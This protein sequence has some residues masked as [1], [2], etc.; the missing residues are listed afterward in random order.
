MKSKIFLP[1]GLAT[2]AACALPACDDYLEV[3]SPSSFSD[4]YVFGTVDEINKNL[5]AVYA[6]MLSSNTYGGAYINTYCLNSDVEMTTNGSE[7]Q[8]S[9]GNSYRFFDATADGSN[10]NNTWRDA[11][12]NIEYANN[13][14]CGVENTEFY[15]DPKN[16]DHAEV[17][18]MIGEAKC[19]R[20][21]NYL[22]LVVLCGDVPF[23]FSRT[24]DNYDKLVMPIADRDAILD[25]LIE[26]LEKAAPDMKFASD[27]T[28]ERC[29][30][31]FAWALIARI[32][33]FRGGYSLRPEGA[34]NYK[35]VR[36]SDYKNYYKKA[37]AYTDSVINKSNH[38]LNKSYRQV[39]VDECNYK[40]DNSDDP[41]FE[42][43]LT[44]GSSGNIGYVHGPSVSW[45][46][47]DNDKV[48]Y[49]SSN[50]GLQLNAFYRWTF[51]TLDLRR[52]FVVGYW[53]YKD[54]YT[55]AKS[56]AHTNE[57]GSPSLNIGGLTYRCN[58]WSKLWRENGGFGS[59]TSGNT[60]IN[61]PYM[62]YADVL[63]MYAEAVNEV[64][65][66]PTAEALEAL[67]QVRR[68]AGL[69]DVSTSDYNEFFTAIFNERAWEFAGEN[70]RW[71][72]LVRW[73]KYSEVIYRQF[74]NY[75]EFAA[76]MGS[77][78]N[79][80]NVNNICTYFAS[81]E[82]VKDNSVKIIKSD[83]DN[84]SSLT[85]YYYC[86]L[87]NPVDI[88]SYPCTNEKYNTLE[89]L[90]VWG[91]PKGFT[92]PADDKVTINGSIVT[93]AW[94]RPTSDLS[95]SWVDGDGN[96]RPACRLSFRGYMYISSNDVPFG[97]CNNTLSNLPPV[98]YIL[99]IPRTFVN[100]S[101][102]QYVNYYGY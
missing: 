23:S 53:D 10:I 75:Y 22:D 70:I 25:S 63:L 7:T 43:P 29:S 92:K 67:N 88:N 50:G 100:R 90:N 41:I 39:F 44:T 99:P 11:Y 60:G 79:E 1:I 3:D 33:L 66:A 6:Y 85:N 98:R 45:T 30:K 62:R 26:D 27:V 15:T 19:I 48:G 49:G 5:N 59:G 14:V 73:N 12:A 96:V 47:T 16:D 97:A 87:P 95:S 58:K 61:F 68:R 102:G 71:K 40:I 84:M 35:M 9:N 13:F 57:E 31:E 34:S 86:F 93:R 2:L 69:P 4:E 52:D 83:I 82:D 36:P 101:N 74:Y 89:I 51:D 37:V 20:A 80:E 21:M 94:I 56:V 76:N 8:N 38:A 42:I 54:N 72:D 77:G 91:T 65:G 46:S 18:Q 78:Y 32:S 81:A 17:M 64:E 24:A 55:D 28:V